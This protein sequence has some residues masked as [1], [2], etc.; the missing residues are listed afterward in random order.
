MLTT[1]TGGDCVANPP[2]PRRLLEVFVDC[3]NT[4]V[5]GTV[6]GNGGGGIEA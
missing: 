6:E 5:E 4:G 1:W 3:N 2:K